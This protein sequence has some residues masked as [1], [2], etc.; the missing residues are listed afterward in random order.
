MALIYHFQKPMI[1]SLHDFACKRGYKR[2]KHYSLFIIIIVIIHYMYTWHWH[3]KGF[4]QTK[5]CCCWR[6]CCCYL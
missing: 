1:G 3:I 4:E 6:R 2:F 5:C